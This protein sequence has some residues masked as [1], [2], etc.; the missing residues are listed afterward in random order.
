M[1][2][3][4]ELSTIDNELLFDGKGTGIYPWKSEPKHYSNSCG[5]ELTNLRGLSIEEVLQYK[6]YTA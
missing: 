5:T 6:G 2:K 1:A 3:K 4:W